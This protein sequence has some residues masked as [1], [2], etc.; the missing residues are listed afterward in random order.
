MLWLLIIGYVAIGFAL[1]VWLIANE[2]DESWAAFVFF[3]WPFLV[4]AGCATD[5]MCAMFIA[6]AMLAKVLIHLI[7]LLKS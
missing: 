3:C 2:E 4:V 7:R 5:I 6:P 1:A